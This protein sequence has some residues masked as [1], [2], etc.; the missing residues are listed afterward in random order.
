MSPYRL[1]EH[2]GLIDFE[3]WQ[4]EGIRI[5]I[6]DKDGTLTSANNLELVPEVIDGLRCNLSGVFSAIALVSNNQD[7]SQVQ[8]LKDILQ[9]ELKVSVFA[10]C[11]ADKFPRKP[12]IAMG[13]EV[14]K[15]FGVSRSELATVGDRRFTDVSFGRK[16]GAGAIALCK[17]V[18]VG[19]AKGVAP[20]RKLEDHFVNI[21]RSLQ[22]AA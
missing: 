15:H 3:E 7:P 18:G 14:A 12:N 22:I 20:I 13:L 1:Y 10:I 19:E 9:D 11:R 2:A 5:P 4:S 8:Q 17:K 6:F 16:L 21:E